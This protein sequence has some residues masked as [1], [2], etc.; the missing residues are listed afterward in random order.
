MLNENFILFRRRRPEVFYEKDVLRNFSQFTGKHLYQR[1]F[2]KKVQ[3]L[4]AWP[5]FRKSVLFVGLEW[6]KAVYFEF[7]YLVKSISHCI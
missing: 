5:N 3:F 1:L 6:I 2:F 4:D 7:R